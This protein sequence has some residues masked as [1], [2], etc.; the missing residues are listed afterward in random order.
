MLNA[1]WPI[2]SFVAAREKFISSISTTAARRYFVSDPD[3]ADSLIRGDFVHL[4]LRITG[5]L[6]F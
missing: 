6:P 4:H 1:D 3:M 2:L 5:V